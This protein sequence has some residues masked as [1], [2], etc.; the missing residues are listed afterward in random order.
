MKLTLHEL[1]KQLS[2][3]ILWL[4]MALLVLLNVIF[5]FREIEK[6]YDA[7]TLAAM[8]AAESIVRENPEEVYR[9]YQTMLEMQKIYDAEVEKWFEAQMNAIMESP[10]DLPPEPEEPQ[11]PSEYYEG[12]ND[13]AFLDLY[14]RN[15][16]TA[17]EYNAEISEKRAIAEDTVN[18]YRAAGYSRDT[19]SYRYQVRFWNIY[20]EALETVKPND[21]LSYGWDAFWEY[22]GSGIFLLLAAILAGSRLF[23]IERDSGMEPVLRATRRGRFRLAI[24]KIGAAVLWMLGISLLF[25]LSALVVCG[26]RYGL[27]S[28]FAPLQQ[29]T[30]MLYWPYPFSQ[31][32]T[33]LLTVL[34]SALASLAICL[35]TACFTLLLKRALPAIAISAAVVGVEFYLLEKGGEF[36]SAVNLLTA[37]NAFRLWERWLPIHFMGSPVSFLPVLL[38]A[39]LL[40]ALITALLSLERWVHRGMGSR[41]P[42]RILPQLNRRL[43]R[44]ISLPHFHSIRLFPY[45][46][47]KLSSIRM[48]LICLLLIALQ[49]GISMNALNG[50]PTFYD[51]M[52]EGYM[53]EY[54]GMTLEESLSEIGDRLSIYKEVTADGKSLDMA[55]KRLADEITYEEYVAYCN[56]L[57]EALTHMDTLSAYQQELTYLCEKTDETG[58]ATRPVLST[59][60]VT[61][62]ARPF[63]IPVVAL[64]FVLL[65]G[66]FAREHE[67]KFLPLLRTAP[68]GR[69]PVWTAKLRMAMLCSLAVAAG[70]LIFDLVL[71][72][73]RYPTDYL[74]APLFCIVRYKNTTTGITAGEYLLLVCLLRALGTLLWGLIITSLSQLLRSEWATAGCMLLF[75]LPYGLTLLGVPSAERFDVTLLLS[76]DRLWLASTEIGGMMLL[77]IFVAV[78]LLITTVLTAA[79]Y[80]KFCK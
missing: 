58:I 33:F 53:Q 20:G 45:E 3:R 56:L 25:H 32:G 6:D 80:K 43:K 11:F 78:T 30:A 36:F 22:D 4:V 26:Y 64:L 13:F 47:H 49:A 5:C 42:R 15:V 62:A 48:T 8:K 24:G 17:D 21:S 57:N 61:W 52:K 69:R 75:F 14:Y 29:S 73:V 40:I 65:A 60:F 37:T 7:E 79:S 10:D 16:L 44:P 54:E 46:F 9:R 38:V 23:T 72:M 31:L 67:S 2:G 50:E 74:S 68:K 28:P 77:V 76:G 55:R 70:A 39:L 27:S 59:G 71:L 19:Y 51:E 12:M 41:A 35:L 63:D 1:Y 18:E 34:F 66:I